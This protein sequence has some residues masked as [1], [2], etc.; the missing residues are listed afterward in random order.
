M[1]YRTANRHSI[2][3]ILRRFTRTIKD[4]FTEA[5][6]DVTVTAYRTFA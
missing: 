6:E 2:R 5:F 4:A 1:K 3:F